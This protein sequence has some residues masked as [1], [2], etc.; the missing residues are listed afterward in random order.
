MNNVYNHVLKEKANEFDAKI[1]K[2][3]ESVADV[4]C[5][6]AIAK[7]KK[8]CEI[9]CE[10]F[11]FCVQYSYCFCNTLKPQKIAQTRINKEKPLKKRLQS[12]EKARLL[13]DLFRQTATFKKLFY[14]F[15]F[16]AVRQFTRQC[17]F[18][19]ER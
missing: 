4:N 9:S 6:S 18:H 1:S 13:L 17:V 16:L 15:N 3:F 5:N 11:S 7:N 12:V 19:S 14:A 8:A 2:H 10:V